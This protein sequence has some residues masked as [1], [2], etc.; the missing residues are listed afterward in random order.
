M[1]IGAGAQLP[2]EARKPK[3]LRNQAQAAGAGET[4]TVKFEGPLEGSS[5]KE[6]G[7][8]ESVKGP[9]F[10]VCNISFVSNTCIFVSV[11]GINIIKDDAF[12][13]HLW[14]MLQEAVPFFV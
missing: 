8:A 2:P 13:R 9:R 10:V 1:Y 5:P 4:P 7:D 3:F 12:V 6:L 14:N 11:C